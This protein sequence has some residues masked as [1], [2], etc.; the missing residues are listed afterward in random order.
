MTAM[1]SLPGLERFADCLSGLFR[2]DDRPG[3]SRVCEL[4][5]A[6]GR[7]VEPGMAL[8]TLVTHGFPYALVH[9]VAR[10]FWR[11]EPG[12]SL[13]TMGAVNHAVIM[14][15]GGL[16]ERIVTSYCGDVYPAPGPN[17][18]FNR[19]YLSGRVEI[20]NC[21]LLSYTLRLL[22]AALGLPGLPA[23]TLAGS[24]M[25]DG[26]ASCALV[27]DPWSGQALPWVRALVPD[28]SL[29]HGWA[30]DS[31]GNTIFSPPLAEGLWGALAARRG[32]VV[33]VERI[34]SA[35]FIRA[36][37][38]LPVLPAR[39]VRAVVELPFGSHP[40][41]FFGRPVQGAQTY[42]EDY[43]F[44]VEFR[45]ANRD[46]KRFAEWLDR[47]V[48][49]CADHREYL[50]RL[51]AGRLADLVAMGRSE[52][53]QEQLLDL[54]D[55]IRLD[56]PPLPS[57]RM[58]VEAA[59]RISA[60]CEQRGRS[61]VLAGQGVSNL[62]AWLAVLDLKRRGLEVE[63]VAEAGFF[64]YAPRPA[65]PFIFNFANL[66]QCKALTDS[67]WTLGAV[68]GGARSNSVGSL[69]A[70]QVDRRANVN[71][72]VIPDV[73]YL[74]GS[75][76]ACDVLSSADEV[77][78][79]AVMTPMRYV[80]EVP[81]VTGPG[82]RVSAVVSDKAVFERDPASGE[83]VLV[84]LVPQGAPGDGDLASRLEE[85]ESLLGWKPR[86]AP[87]LGWTAEPDAESLCALRLLDPRRAF[88]KPPRE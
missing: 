28:L 76:G 48:L 12:F 60:S 11:R 74:V 84:S 42:A 73:F 24:S 9:E 35:D 31:S 18:A 72:T 77:I 41:G 27:A 14:L 61:A 17:P 21:S 81:Y 69:S 15:A 53:W 88:L 49:G 75:G 58:A 39:Y 51:G 37:A 83:L 82:D 19:A 20:E 79:S 16:L 65:S 10:R 47:W 63:L 64:G 59:R 2:V 38:H 56:E 36:H 52:A 55:G 5:E 25:A 45:H 44:I 87:E 71:S 33:S 4:G 85:V 70:G 67:L 80:D 57:E 66:P 29:V 8:H 43:D 13:L 78:L 46:E 30:A 62:A 50:Q 32:A 34:V 7:F 54:A 23:R 40:A 1:P 86:L 26:S 6:I 3:P 22:A 68:V